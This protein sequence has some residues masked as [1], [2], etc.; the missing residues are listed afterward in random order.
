MRLKFRHAPQ[1][2]LT[3]VSHRTSLLSFTKR[4]LF[5]GLHNSCLEL[6]GRYLSLKENVNFVIGSV[7]ELGKPVVAP[8]ST[9]SGERNPEKAGFALPVESTGIDHVRVQDVE[10]ETVNL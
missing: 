5:I 8:H 3:A 4:I 2:Y 10:N 6:P 9:S 1:V 7:L